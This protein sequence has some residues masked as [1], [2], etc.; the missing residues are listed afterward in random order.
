MRFRIPKASFYRGAFFF[1]PLNL[2]NISLLLRTVPNV[3]KGWLMGETKRIP[4]CKTSSQLYPH[5]EPHPQFN[6]KHHPE[7]LTQP[8]PQPHPRPPARPHDDEKERRRRGH[9]RRGGRGCTVR[10]APQKTRTTR[11]RTMTRGDGSEE[12]DWK[13]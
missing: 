6:P 7:L 11:T 2:Q 5:P 13:G 9:G 3:I 8:H 12:K 10:T 4:I 1:A